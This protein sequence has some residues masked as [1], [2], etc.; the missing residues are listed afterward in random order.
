MENYDMCILYDA[1]NNWQLEVA[2]SCDETMFYYDGEYI[3]EAT[4]HK[5]FAPSGTGNF[6]RVQSFCLRVSIITVRCRYN[7]VNY[8]PSPH[9]WHPILRHEGEVHGVLVSSNSD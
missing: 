8:H 7:V 6:N 9:Q 3:R 5:Y 1:G 4:T 2:S